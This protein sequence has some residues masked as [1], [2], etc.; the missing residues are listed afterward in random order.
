MPGY[1]TQGA[2]ARIGSDLDPLG[3]LLPPYIC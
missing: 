1:Y 2:H 3:F